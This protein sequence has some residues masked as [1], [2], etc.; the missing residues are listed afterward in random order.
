M[1][2]R[3]EMEE[4]SK[5][6]TS[7]SRLRVSRREPT[8]RVSTLRVTVVP[9]PLDPGPSTVSGG[10]NGKLTVLTSSMLEMD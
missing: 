1:P 4:R 3:L 10:N 5:D 9:E 2:S 8:T 6:S 7:I